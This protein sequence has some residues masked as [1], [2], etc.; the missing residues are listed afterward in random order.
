[1]VLV[2]VV[3]GQA[4]CLFGEKEL[5]EGRSKPI[6]CASKSPCKLYRVD[7]LRELFSEPINSLSKIASLSPPPPLLLLRLAFSKA[8]LRMTLGE[9][10][11]NP[12]MPPHARSIVD[13][14]CT[15][16]AAKGKSERENLRSGMNFWATYIDR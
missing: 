11:S 7:F 3:V 10:A 1:M 6:R 12:G 9:F 16:R 8:V 15:A 4:D 14:A 13:S 5:M 2:S